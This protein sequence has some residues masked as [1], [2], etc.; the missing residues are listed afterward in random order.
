M[1]QWYRIRLPKQETQVRSLIQEDPTLQEQLSLS[2][3]TAT[4]PTGPR[5]HVPQQEQPLQCK[6][7]AL[8]L[9]QCGPSAEENK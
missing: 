1:A 5:A 9:E 3:T 2:C 8:Q 6:A 4:E 7:Q